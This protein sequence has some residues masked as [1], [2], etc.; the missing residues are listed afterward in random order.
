MLTGVGQLVAFLDEGVFEK[1]GEVLLVV[2][3]IDES[4]L[5]RARSQSRPLV[6]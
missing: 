6:R 3:S 4:L 5:D 1:N 2:A